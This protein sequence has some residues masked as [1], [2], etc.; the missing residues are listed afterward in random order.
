M[1]C[2]VNDSDFIETHYSYGGAAS[3]IAAERK[4]LSRNGVRLTSVFLSETVLQ[5][6]NC[7]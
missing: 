4:S 1:F 5:V 3:V 7:A 2:P 6:Q